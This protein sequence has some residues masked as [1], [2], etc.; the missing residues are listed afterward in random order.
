MRSFFKSMKKPVTI[1]QRD[2][3]DCGAASLASVAAYYKLKLPVSRI[4]Q[5]AS[6]D[7]KGTNVL[8]LIEAAAR[9]GFDAK[10]VRGEYESLYKVPTPAI[11]H[12]VVKE[13]LYHYVVI[14]NVTAK[15]VQVMD[16][17]EGAVHKYSHQ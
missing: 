9:I 10:G 1:R 14:Y 4:R 3:T 8:G 17:A 5:F 6:T 16:P 7:K 2:I 12:I 13:V 15:F 11:A